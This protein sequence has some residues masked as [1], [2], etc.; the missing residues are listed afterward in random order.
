M[1]YLSNLS[2]L[3]KKIM[4]AKYT[5]NDDVHNN[6]VP[7]DSVATDS[8]PT[9]S[10]PTDS[11][12]SEYICNYDNSIQTAGWTKEVIE[13]DI[14]N[15]VICIVGSANSGKT[16]FVDNFCN[17][18]FNKN[19]ISSTE[20]EHT[21]MNINSSVGNINTHLY[22]IPSSLEYL[23]TIDYGVYPNGCIIMFD[24]TS[25]ESFNEVEN[26]L[27]KL[28]GSPNITICGNKS[29]MI[30]SEQMDKIYPKVNL[31]ALKYNTDYHTISSKTNYNNTQPIY[32]LLKQI[33]KNPSI[34]F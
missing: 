13:L 27:R 12:K 10:V 1:Q 19:Y 17:Q 15:P 33:R 2:N 8:V 4:Y 22:V 28:K 32:D 30:T 9:D 23:D 3:F 31:L 6:S 20:V 5:Q 25:D 26:H 7:T 34:N 16:V 24:L 11:N 29:D 21:E 14:E 18:I